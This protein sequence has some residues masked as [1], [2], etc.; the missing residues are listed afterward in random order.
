MFKL[1]QCSLSCSLELKSILEKMIDFKNIKPKNFEYILNIS[2]IKEFQKDSIIYYENDNIDNLY[3]L[4]HGCVKAYKIN[5][6]N[7]EV[8]YNLYLNNCVKLNNP[9]L[10]NYRIL[11]D[12]LSSFNLVCMENCKILSINAES[13]RELIK[14]DSTLCLNMLNRANQ[15]IIDQDYLIGISMLY[16]AKA[17][18]ASLLDKTPDIFYFLNKKIISQILNISQE[19][20]S[21]NLQKLKDDNIITLDNNKNIIVSD[22]ERLNQMF[23]N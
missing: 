1:K 5:K 19:T 6:F 21:R 4:F 15:V 23:R 7:N 13:F 8:I 11:I 12:N 10:M 18:I 14:E 17:K 3:Y 16:D 2:H 9:L 22:K 20:L